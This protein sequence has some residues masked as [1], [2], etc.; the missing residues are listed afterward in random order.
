MRSLNE[1]LTAD[2]RSTVNESSADNTIPRSVKAL[3]KIIKQR[4]IEQGPNCDLNDID[5]SRMKS[6]THLFCGSTKGEDKILT[7]FNGDI[8]QWDVSNVKDMNAMFERSVFNS[9]ISK[10]DVSNVEDMEGMFMGSKF[11]GDISKWDVS[12]VDNMRN[13]FRG[14]QFNGD[15]SNWN[16]SSLLNMQ[17]MFYSSKFNGDISRWNISSKTG[18]WS[19]SG[20]FKNSPLE[21]K[22]PSWYKE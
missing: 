8:S 1:Y 9:D 3:Q 5:V 20:M 19:M 18:P 10:W 6:M 21:G 13:M 16:V 11:T 12:N 15:I 7:S 2:E 22:E 17:C 14:S 4:I